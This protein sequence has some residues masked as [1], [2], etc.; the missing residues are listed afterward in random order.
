MLFSFRS[1]N[2]VKSWTSPLRALAFFT[3]FK[4]WKMSEILR[5]FTLADTFQLMLEKKWFNKVPKCFTCLWNSFKKMGWECSQLDQLVSPNAIEKLGGWHSTE[6]AFALLTQPARVWFSA[7]PKTFRNFLMSLKFN[8]SA[9]LRECTVQSLIV[10]QT[11][12]VLVS[13]KLVL[14]K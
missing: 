13:G 14:Q 9:L 6:L 11:H 4:C 5:D 12:L 8:D 2:S 10:V 1:Q 7:F 3:K